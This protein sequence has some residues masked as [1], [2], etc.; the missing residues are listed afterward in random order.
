MQIFLRSCIQA[1]QRSGMRAH[2]MGCYALIVLFSESSRRMM[3]DTI[4]KIIRYMTTYLD[5]NLKDY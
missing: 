5:F 2:T 1:N 3:Q 4:V